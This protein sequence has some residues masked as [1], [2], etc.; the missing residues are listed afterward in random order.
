MGRAATV[1]VVDDEAYVRDS[2]VA[3][4]RR[5]GHDARGV[6]SAAEALR[7]L[8]EA[9]FDALITD[10]RMPDV[11]GLELLRRLAAAASG[12]PVIVLTGHGTVA[13]AVE[14]MK[15]GAADYLLK[16][17]DP[18]QIALILE[19]VVEE[20]SLRRE[21]DYLRGSADDEEAEAVGASPAWQK[22]LRMV[23][24]A[25]QTHS[26]ILLV[27]ESGTGK[28]I[29]ARR[30]HRRSPRAERPFVSVNCAA[31][32]L[33]LFES[34]FFGFRKGA[35]TG[36][37]TDRDGRFRVADGGTLFMDE[38][39]AM[40]EA[41]Q[42]KILR[43]I[44][45]GV[46]ERLGDTRATRVDVRLVA[47]TNVVLEEAVRAGRFRSDLFYRLNVVQIR[48]PPLRE[49]P[50]DI[51]LLA[52]H[53]L[54]LLAPR[55]GRRLQGIEPEA[56]QIL[57]AWRWPGNARELRNV[58]ERALIVEPGPRLTAASLPPDVREGRGPERGAAPPPGG[59][60]AGRPAGAPAGAGHGGADAPGDAAIAGVA[61]AAGAAGMGGAGFAARA[62]LNLRRALGERERDFLVAALRQAQGVR[63]EAARLLGIDQRN[64]SYYLRKH[65]LDPDEVSR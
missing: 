11:D 30:I 57:S 54:R 60:A 49:R 26:T 37:A 23:D 5:G 9:S 10:L 16:P 46:F 59:A 63:K 41:A 17:A 28:E 52:E 38:V 29:L 44:Q 20:G 53:F 1:L 22:V 24:T 65:G 43:V 8:G 47:A 40:P 61:G 2:L 19:R 12:L 31:V 15:A 13:S 55:V 35:F 3:V 21:L 34:E 36:A 18:D 14:C 58:I 64:L 7:A 6:A 51:P 39:G 32:P 62:D 27:G 42:A 33:E 56:M 50:E 45:D 25:A 4:L 48:V